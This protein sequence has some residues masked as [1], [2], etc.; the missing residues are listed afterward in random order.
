MKRTLHEGTYF[1]GRAIGQGDFHAIS[2]DGSV[3]MACNSN[4][5]QTGQIGLCT[6]AK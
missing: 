1:E 5:Q 6:L 4:F 2:E 3:G